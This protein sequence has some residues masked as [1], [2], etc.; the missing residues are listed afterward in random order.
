VHIAYLHYL[1]ES[2]TAQ[3]HVRQFVSAARGLGHIVDVYP[4][5]PGTGGEAAHDSAGLSQRLRQ[6]LKRHLSY[7][8]HEVKEVALNVGYVR[9]ER[10]LLETRRPDVLLV[11]DAGFTVSYFH[12]SRRLGI[13]L[14]MEV[15]APAAESRLYLDQ[16]WHLPIVPEWLEAVK[17]RHADAVIVVSSALRD[18]LAERSGRPPE[19]FVVAPNGADPHRFH[20]ALVPDPDVERALGGGPVVGFVGSFQKFHGSE[21]LATLMTEVTAA[22]PAARFLLIGDGPDAGAVERRAREL[23]G[24]ALFQGRVSHEQIPRLVAAFDVGV[25]PESNFY[26]SPLKVLEW[27]AA[28]RGVVAPAYGPLRE[29]IEDGVDGLL[30]P[31]GDAQGLVR[32]VLRLTD[33]R[34]LR[35]RLGR[36]A[37]ARVRSSLTWRHN[38]A[39]VL[40]A[41][42]HA[43]ASHQRRL[44]ARWASSVAVQARVG[45][46]SGDGGD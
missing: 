18:H 15:N 25:M 35:Q 42:E 23:G 24:R 22:R 6:S 38:A 9:Q 11:R 2:D 1:S 17:I 34:E 46:P 14:A 3:H 40:G 37:A 36:A 28:G 26:G 13:P 45:A 30:F 10:R 16:Y 29:L 5:N 20:Q 19:Q 21:L 8:L 27:M 33:D 32:A 7:A 44:P 41:C 39:R 31:P 43:I 12:A 4:M